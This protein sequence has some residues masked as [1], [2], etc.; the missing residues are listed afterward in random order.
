MGVQCTV[1][2]EASQGIISW[3]AGTDTALW[4]HLFVDCGTPGY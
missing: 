2:L 1:F 4:H 3:L